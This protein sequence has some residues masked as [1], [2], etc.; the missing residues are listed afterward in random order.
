MTLT[1]KLSADQERRLRESGRRHD[2]EALQHVLAQA[3]QTSV[4]ALEQAPPAQPTLDKMRSLLDRVNAE[5][6]DAPAIT[7]LAASRSEI[8]ADRL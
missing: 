5:L 8:Y 3:V 2:P 6:R 7:D 4:E 1:V